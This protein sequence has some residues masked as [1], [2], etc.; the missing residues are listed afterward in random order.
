MNENE[1]VSDATPQQED[2]IPT[3]QSASGGDLD[4]LAEG[5]RHSLGALA[6][7]ATLH[8][9]QQFQE[10]VG[11]A[12]ASSLVGQVDLSAITA[13]VRQ[14]I[15][16]SMPSPMQ[17]KGL[18]EAALGAYGMQKSI[19]D[20]INKWLVP[21]LRQ[22]SD[23]RLYSIPE[24][25]RSPYSDYLTHTSD[26]FSQH[27]YVIESV[28]DLNDAISTL[29]SKVPSSTL[30]W[31]GQQSVSWG[32]HSSLFRTLSLRNGVDRPE[33]NPE[34]DQ[35]FPT[36][37]Q[38]VAAEAMI[39]RA[40]RRQW[41]FD[42]LSALETFARIQHAGG[43]TRLLDVTFNPYIAAWFATEANSDTDVDDSRLVALATEP[44]PNR[45]GIEPATS[46]IELDSAWGSHLPLWH[47][48]TSAQERQAIDWGTGSRRR[49]WVPPA[50]DP[51][52]AAQNAAF[53]IDGVPITSARTAPYF[54]AGGGP[55]RYFKR[56][57]LLAAGS[58]LM[59]TASPRRKPQPNK[60]NLAPAFPFRITAE[61]KMPIRKYLERTFGYSRPS[62]YPDINALARETHKLEFL[63][64]A[65]LE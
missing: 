64:L 13:P 25:S 16:A 15:E 56:A 5:A 23:P 20:S 42:G 46:R 51:R 28:N 52:I 31:R 30:V 47:E 41:R 10:S 33:D 58:M 7:P 2:S 59:R 60:R 24:P 32:L 1:D 3:E 36:E 38:M 19:T 40:A 45:D 62:V 63:R 22:I 29:V 18:R 9:T 14:A 21:A 6:E 43:V 8:G 17:L 57:D 55:N 11:S 4:I 34:G 53:V 61:A 35:P 65:D 37:D 50:Y 44:V 48:L 12:L 27:E 49:L 26:Y 39:L 54:T